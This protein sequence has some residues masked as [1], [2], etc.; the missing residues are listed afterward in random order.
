[1]EIDKF[2]N[3]HNQEL[4]YKDVDARV[5]DWILAIVNKEPYKSEIKNFDR[6]IDWD[7]L[8]EELIQEGN[9]DYMS[10]WYLPKITIEKCVKRAKD[11]FMEE[12]RG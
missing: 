7:K 2:G 5:T 10:Q 8:L 12:I 6:M 4:N 1:M 9:D 11:I 3:K